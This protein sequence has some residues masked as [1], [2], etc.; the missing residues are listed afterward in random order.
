MFALK[1][2]KHRSQKTPTNITVTV[3]ETGIKRAIV[4]KRNI[5]CCK[6]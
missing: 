5:N 3:E 1:S 2:K 6:R 4:P